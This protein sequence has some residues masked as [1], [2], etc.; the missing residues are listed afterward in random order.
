MQ[1]II[2]S[3]TICGSL[4]ATTLQKCVFV[5]DTVCTALVRVGSSRVHGKMQYIF[6]RLPYS[7]HLL[8]RM[9]CYSVHTCK[10]L[11][12]I[13]R[14]AVQHTSAAQ[15]AVL[16][17]VRV[18]SMVKSRVHGKMQY[19]FFRLPYSTHLLRRMQCYSVHTCKMLC[20]ITR[21]AVQHTSAA[22]NA[23][24]SGVRVKSTVK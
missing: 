5:P 12:I 23:V 15:N 18:K 10:M 13:T 17:G 21:T 22:Q 19:I 2:F 7:T 11:C 24:L 16:S 9:Q 6:F 14:T 8:R 4:I 3:C 1:C 20:I